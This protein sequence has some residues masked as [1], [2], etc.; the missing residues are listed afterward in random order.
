[1]T[2]NNRA[3]NSIIGDYPQCEESKE[4]NFNALAPT[5]KRDRKRNRRRGRP[6]RRKQGRP[7]RKPT[8][9]ARLK[10]M[11]N[12]DAL[13]SHEEAASK[14]KHEDKSQFWKELEATYFRKIEPSEVH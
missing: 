3:D 14:N 1:M 13:V 12:R 6:G 8:Q 7:A 10:L 11:L 9:V 4:T 2:E 5:R